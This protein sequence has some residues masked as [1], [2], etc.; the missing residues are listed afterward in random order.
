MFPCFGGC[1]SIRIVQQN[2]LAWFRW[3]VSCGS[4]TDR[5]SWYIQ[6]GQFVALRRLFSFLLFQKHCVHIEV[7]PNIYFACGCCHPLWSSP[8]LHLGTG[9]M[10]DRCRTLYWLLLLQ[11]FS[12]LSVLLM[13]PEL[14]QGSKSFIVGPFWWYVSPVVLFSA[15][16]IWMVFQGA[17][18][19]R[20]WGY[21]QC[22][23]SYSTYG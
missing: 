10:G 15:L 2:I 9:P 8:N 13:N 7:V 6:Q 12:I 14:N 19:S 21:P 17:F 11:F 18:V 22:S 3:L 1:G 20:C 5:S 16:N 23:S 4:S